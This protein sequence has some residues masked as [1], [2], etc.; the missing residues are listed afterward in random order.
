VGAGI[1]IIILATSSWGLGKGKKEV[2]GWKM[3]VKGKLHH[4]F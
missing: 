1:D 4:V 2:L 3:M